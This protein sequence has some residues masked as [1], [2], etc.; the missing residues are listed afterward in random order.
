MI[1]EKAYAKLNLTLS[2]T[3]RLPDGY[4]SLETVMQT[5]SLCDDVFVS[6]A[7]AIN[8]ECGELS[9]GD[10]LAYKAAKAF[11]RA[12]GINGGADITVTKRIP[13]C[14]GFGGG[15]ADAAAVLRAL[16]VIYDAR[17]S[18]EELRMIALP[19]GA[20]VPFLIS[21][22]TALCTGKGELIAPVKNNAPLFYCVC[23][24]GE[25]VSTARMFSLA[26]NCSFF[27]PRGGEMTRALDSGD[28]YAVACALH[29]DF[30]DICA[31]VCPHTFM[32]R[33]ALVTNG[34]LASSLT[35]SGSGCFGVFVDLQSA[36]AASAALAAECFAAVAVPA[37]D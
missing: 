24:P 7:A 18:A 26:D 12:T 31:S 33:A 20:D 2:I 28:I 16:N 1:T 34:A 23:A 30:A 35:G 8:V 9:G 27:P 19:L 5:I 15:S 4:H 22:G 32:L 17:L 29:N 36:Q 14:G 6:R 37:G 21:G 11:F 3:G 25:G 10:N 13:V